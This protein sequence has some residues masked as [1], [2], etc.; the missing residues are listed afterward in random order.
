MF[1][2]SCTY[3]LDSFV[4]LELKAP[5]FPDASK[6]ENP[7]KTVIIHGASSSVG[8]F[9]TQLAHL[10]KYKVV[11]IAGSS[12]DYAKSLGADIIVDYRNKSEDELAS[13]IK[14]AVKSLGLPVAGVYDAV[15]EEKTTR[16]LAEKVLQPDGGNITTV[17]PVLEKDEETPSNVQIRRTMV[18]AFSPDQK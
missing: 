1:L 8:A 10:A 17:L 14:E 13:D 7:K 11:G 4:R 18:S 6:T 15:S 5:S 9:A 2:T 12:G 16:M 3:T